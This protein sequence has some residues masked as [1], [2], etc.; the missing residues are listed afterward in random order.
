LFCEIFEKHNPAKSIKTLPF[1]YCTF[2]RMYLEQWRF[3]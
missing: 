3:W 1:I 2:H